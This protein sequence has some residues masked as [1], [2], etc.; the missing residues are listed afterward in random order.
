MS[1]ALE[2]GDRLVVVP[3]A[4]VRP[5]QLIAVRDPRLPARVMVK[6]VWAVGPD[7]V[8]V[9]GDNTAGSTDSRHFGP[10]RSGAV[11]G[12]VV[13]RYRPPDRAGWIDE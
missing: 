7:G 2:P 6:R 8:D 5:G 9:R 12:R 1:P 10:V 3:V 4:R 11:V 13:Y